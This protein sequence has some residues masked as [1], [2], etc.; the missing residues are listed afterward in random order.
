M[1]HTFV[2]CAY[3]ES[4]YL[5]ACIQSLL[6]QTVKSEI[7]IAT[8]TPNE[9]IKGIAEK[10]NFPLYIND[11]PSNIASDWNFGYSKVATPYLTIAHQDDIYLPEYT[12]HVLKAFEKSSKPLIFFSD[13]GE[14]REDKVVTKN[15]L[16]QVKR[17]M[18]IPLQIKAFLEADL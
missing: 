11:A 2:V 17:I 10:Y 6:T 8:S 16:L 7:I 13:Y 14:L 12:E 18:L 4:P 3:K 1:K 5:E 15:R 9:H